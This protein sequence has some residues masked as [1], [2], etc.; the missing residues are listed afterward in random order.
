MRVISRFAAVLASAFAALTLV[1]TPARAGESAPPQLTSPMPEEPL[2]FVVDP[3]LGMEASVR[4]ID[5]LGRLAFRFEDAIPNIDVDRSTIPGKIITFVGRGVRLLFLDEPL[6]EVA[7]TVTHEVG[8]H[9]ARARELDLKPSFLFYLPGIYRTLFSPSDHE[10][11]GAYTSYGTTDVVEDTRDTLGTLGGLESQYTQAWWINARIVRAQGWVSHGDL[12]M[13]GASKLTYVDSV[14]ASSTSIRNASNGGNDIASYVT[15]LQDRYNLWRNEDRRR[16]AHRLAA[17]Y[18]WNLVDP[19]LIWSVWG[20]I[21]A[22]L[23]RGDRY[24]QMPLPTIKNLMV[25]PSPRFNLT[26]FGSEQA[27]D[28]FIARAG[29]GEEPHRDDG[30]D[31][32]LLDVYGRVGTSGLAE[33]WGLG[34]RLLGVELGRRF[35]LGGELDVW[36]QP[37]LLLYDRGVFENHDRFGV[38]AGLFGDFR[39]ASDI[40]LTGKLAAKTEGYVMAQPVSSGVHGYVGVSLPWR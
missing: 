18:L 11:V 37:D 13:Y 35:V 36:R 21:F 5:S 30:G 27:L 4:S 2:V 20:G 25:Y 19:T 16:I 14:Y 3:K 24:T 34:A 29:R 1:T 7:T 40:S 23:A 8:G 6:A 12:L 28:V 32:A 15:N 22:P 31:G 33:Y 38:N 17:G 9:G 10:K 26:P 39:I